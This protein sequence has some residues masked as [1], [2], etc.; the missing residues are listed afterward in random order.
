MLLHC[1]Y[2]GPGIDNQCLAQFSLAGSLA[3]ETIANIHT[4]HAFNEFNS[5]SAI[6]RAWLT[7]GSARTCCGCALRAWALGGMTCAMYL[8][9]ALV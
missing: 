7:R 9:Y 1:Q 5:L 4:T 2:C 3:E 8:G 6:Y